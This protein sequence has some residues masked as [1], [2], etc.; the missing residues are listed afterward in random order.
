MAVDRRKGWRHSKRMKRDEG[1]REAGRYGDRG[2]AGIERQG[3]G[4]GSERDAWRGGRER[5]AE[6]G[7]KEAGRER[8]R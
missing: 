4:G 6:E 8:W 1:D 7:D 5:E 2:G 3:L